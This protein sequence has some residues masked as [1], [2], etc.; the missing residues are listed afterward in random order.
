M[1]LCNGYIEQ[2]A[3]CF[4]HFRVFLYF[5]TT[6]MIPIRYGNKIPRTAEMAQQQERAKDGRTLIEKVIPH[7]SLVSDFLA[8]TCITSAA[9]FLDPHGMLMH[10]PKSIDANINP[11][12]QKQKQ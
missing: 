7:V 8:T 11:S 2:V 4:S 5:I 9:C 3:L 1:L 6:D 10:C 12:K